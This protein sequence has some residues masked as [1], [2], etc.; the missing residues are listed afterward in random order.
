MKKWTKNSYNRF[1]KVIPQNNFL[2]HAAFDIFNV[3][4]KRS[5][6]TKIKLKKDITIQTNL[7]KCL[8]LSFTLIIVI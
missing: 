8:Q 3:L 1:V 2:E 6:T 4:V 5:E 7:I